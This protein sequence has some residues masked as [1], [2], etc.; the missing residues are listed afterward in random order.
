LNPSETKRL[1]VAIS[2]PGDILQKLHAATTALA[3]EIPPQAIRWTHPKKLHLTLNF[4]GS[5]EV[6]RIPEIQSALDAAC[7]GH[8]GHE[9]QVAGLGAFPTRS[10]PQIIWAGLAGDLRALESVKRSIDVHFAACGFVAEARPFRP[11]LTLGRASAMS[12]GER[13][14]LAK[15]LDEQRARE[16]GPWQI[17][18]VDLMQSVLS[19][20]G[21]AYTTLESIAL[22]KP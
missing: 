20:Q 17:E 2:P 5:I 8:P 3:K 10:R 1:F 6:A 7:K 22:E 16:F 12:P 11:H 18:K 9:V 19:A 21:T 14:K 4:L 15:V 13:R